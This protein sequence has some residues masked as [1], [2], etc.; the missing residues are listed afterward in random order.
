MKKIQFWSVVIFSSIL[1]L[2][3]SENTSKQPEKD[4]LPGK[5]STDLVHNPGSLQEDTNSNLD[6]AIMSFT[7]TIHDFGRVK[8]GE[9]VQYDFNFKNTGKR[10]LIINE[11]K[12]SCGCTIPKYPSEP[13]QAGSENVIHVTF[14]SK[15]KKGYNEKGIVVITNGNPSV[16]NLT[17]LAEVY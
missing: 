7:D 6:V 12:G 13:I 11:A 15:G 16:S 9:I 3:C 2:D 10:N 8:E 14:D 1:F 17:I 5:L 4:T